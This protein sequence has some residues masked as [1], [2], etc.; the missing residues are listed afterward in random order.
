MDARD[1]FHLARA[2]AHLAAGDSSR[3]ARHLNKCAFGTLRKVPDLPKA[4]NVV[5]PINWPEKL[6]NETPAEKEEKF[7][8][9]ERRMAEQRAAYDKTLRVFERT[10]GAPRFGD[11]QT[12]G[13]TQDEW[14]TKSPAEQEELFARVRQRFRD[15]TPPRYESAAAAAAAYE[16]MTEESL[17]Q[18]RYGP[19]LRWSEFRQ[20]VVDARAAGDFNRVFYLVVHQP[21]ANANDLG[22]GFKEYGIGRESIAKLIRETGKPPAKET[23]TSFGGAFDF[24]WGGSSKKR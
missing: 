19:G 24:L 17:Q 3:A 15:G 16:A 8:R 23:E 20:E 2:Q 7:A 5:R 13:E 18:S 10:T 14:W 22:A 21:I 12:V 4:P 1:R 11:Q 9:G 6:A